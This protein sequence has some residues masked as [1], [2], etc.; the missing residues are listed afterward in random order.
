MYLEGSEIRMWRFGGVVSG[1]YF[2][3]RGKGGERVVMLRVF[4]IVFGVR[5]LGYVF[6]YFG[7]GFILD[8]VMK[9]VRRVFLE[10]KIRFLIFIVF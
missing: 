3:L 8:L 10:M 7:V 9:E 6:F 1:G 2:W 4:K 5:Y